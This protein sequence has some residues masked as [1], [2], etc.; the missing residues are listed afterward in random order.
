MPRQGSNRRAAWA[1]A[2]AATLAVTACG[3]KVPNLAKPDVSSAPGSASA[4]P[5]DQAV[6]SSKPLF[7]LTGLPASTAGA[8]RPAVALLVGGTDPQGLGS[9]DVVYQEAT[10]PARYIALYQSRDATGVGPVT[11]TQP[12]DRQILSQVHPVL[13]Y[14]GAASTYI[15]KS[16][17][18]TT[19]T[20]AGFAAQ[21]G[22]YSDGTEG[23]TTSTQAIAGVGTRQTAPPPLFSY[24]GVGPAAETLASAGLWRPTSATVTVPGLGTEDWTFSQHTDRWTLTS[25]GPRVEVANL[26]IQT[27]AYSTDVINAHKGVSVPVLTVVGSGRAE[28]LSGSVGGGGGGTAASGT[29]SRLHA[30]QVTN[31]FDTSGAPMAFQPGPTWVILAPSGSHVSTSG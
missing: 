19:I 29:W 28:A 11:S 6:S 18:K 16:L 12:T 3:Q 17:D 20:D 24:R 22:L 9:A 13:G 23:L 7:P 15:V 30:G 27:V 2:A 4:S 21:P 14:D 5:S 10:A 1:V 26:I 31:Y 25:G 8:A